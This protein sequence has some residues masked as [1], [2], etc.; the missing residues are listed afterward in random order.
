MLTQQNPKGSECQSRMMGNC[1]VR[2]VGEGDGATYA[3]LPDLEGVRTF[4]WLR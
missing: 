2:F 4:Y 1:Q 3:L